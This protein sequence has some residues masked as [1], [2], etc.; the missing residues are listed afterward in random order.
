MYENVQE[1]MVTAAIVDALEA[2]KCYMQP[3][4]FDDFEKMIDYWQEHLQKFHSLIYSKEI[5]KSLYFGLQTDKL[6]LLTGN[7]GTG[8]T[9][10][11]KAL[12]KSFTFEDAAIISVQSN[13]T[14]KGDL[15]GYYNPIEK[16]YIATEFLDALINFSRLALLNPKNLFIICLDEMNLAHVEHYFAEFLSSLQDNREIVLYSEKMRQNIIRE[17]Q[18]NSIYYQN[19]DGELD[20]EKL[21]TL[22]IEERKYYFELCRMAQMIVHYPAKIKIP[23]NV[24]FFGTLNQDE[25]THDISPKVIDR[26][27]IIRLEKN[28]LQPEKFDVD[29]PESLEYKKLENY[30]STH[31]ETLNVDDFD[32]TLSDVS[33]ISKRVTK[34]VLRNENFETSTK[35]LGVNDIEDFLIASFLL[36]KIRFD[37]DEYRN[38]IDALKNICEGH[39]LSEEILKQI[40]DGKEADFWRR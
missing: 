20:K 23:P 7:P 31:E 12:A 33:N 38:K 29:F 35:I 9:S 8:K 18:A 10:L 34:E 37:E 15:L 13:W 21:A 17:L 25:T 24:K 22:N 39:K 14:D 11:V 2:G 16:N 6:I 40:D 3:Q 19:A 1:E 36:P 28:N 4:A 30:S 26:S 5:L 27:Y 32:K